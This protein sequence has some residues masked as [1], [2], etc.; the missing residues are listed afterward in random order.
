MPGYGDSDLV[1]PLTFEAI[2]HSL[3][4]LLDH[5]QIEKVD[6]VGLSFGGMHA[7][8]TA[9][10][11][12]HRVRR[13]VLADT[14][15]AFGMDGTTEADWTASRLGPLDA[16]RR[17]ADAADIIVDAITA[18]TLTGQIRDETVAAFG[19]ISDAGFR[20]AVECLPTND[21]RAHLADID[22]PTLVVVGELD[23]E[24][25]VSYAQVLADGLPNSEFEVLGG[26][27]HLTPAEAPDRFNQLV[28]Q[29]LLVDN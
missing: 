25:P 10:G 19:Q 5:L 9:I 7:L 13:M 29:F 11:F 26:I 22:H 12:P 18:V 28:S 27:G 15:P 3:I 24:T 6:L 16:G 17:L 4:S 21:I 23:E 20:A 1:E 14:S 8:H 2:A